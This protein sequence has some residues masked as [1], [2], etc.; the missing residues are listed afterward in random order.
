MGPAEFDRIFGRFA[1]QQTVE[2][3]GGETVSATDAVEN[4]ELAL[5]GSIGLAFHP[6]DRAPTVAVRRVHFAQS[7]RDH[8][9]LRVHFHDGPGVARCI[10]YA[11]DFFKVARWRPEL[12]DLLAAKGSVAINTEGQHVTAEALRRLLAGDLDRIGHVNHARVLEYLEHGR[13]CW[14]RQHGIP[15]VARIEVDY[16][17]E[18][19]WDEIRIDTRLIDDE[20]A[21]YRA[22]LEQHIHTE[23]SAAPAVKATV[24]VAFIDAGARQLCSP[25]DFINAAQPAQTA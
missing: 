15:V 13:W 10:D 22:I 23:Q 3:S 6:G 24:Q 21:V 17:A 14:L 11:T 5:R 16:C 25:D 18:I 8:L 1:G 20:D 12:L 4:M 9:H 2:K 7:G 19:F